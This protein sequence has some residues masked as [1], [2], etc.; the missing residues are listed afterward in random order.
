MNSSTISSAEV[1]I[2]ARAKAYSH[3]GVREHRFLLCGNEVRVWDPVAGH[4]TLVHAMSAATMAR[5]AKLARDKS[6]K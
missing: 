4:Y 1:E 6:S 2:T 5:I 3:E